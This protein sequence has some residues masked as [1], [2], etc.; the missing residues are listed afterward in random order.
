M[1]AETSESVTEEDTFLGS[2]ATNDNMVRSVD[3]TT[4]TANDV[5]NDEDRLRQEAAKRLERRRRKMMSPEERLAKIT[6][7]PVSSMSP[8]NESLPS[9]NLTTE[10]TMTSTNHED[11][12]LSGS[13]LQVD[14]PPLETLTRDVSHQTRDSFSNFLPQGSGQECDLLSQLLGA[15]GGPQAAAGQGGQGAPAEGQQVTSVTDI[16]WVMLALA[17]RLILD[18]EFS[19][20]IGDNC[21]LPYLLTLSLLYTLG[22]VQAGSS[23]VSSLLSAALMLCGV[24]AKLVGNLTKT[25]SFVQLLVRTL[26]LYLFTFFISHII[27]IAVVDRLM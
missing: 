6:G 1:A 11:G 21:V 2:G 26:S 25:L 17:V 10:S 27:I 13:S 19:V 18:T 15:A 3:S 22:Y 5:L 12:S 9:S 24:K 14:D 23:T 8:T 4:D 16:V 7:R 20:Y